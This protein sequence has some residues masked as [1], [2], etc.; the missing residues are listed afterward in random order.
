MAGSNELCGL[1]VITEICK[2]EHI[3]GNAEILKQLLAEFCEAPVTNLIENADVVSL[4]GGEFQIDII[5]DP[6]DGYIAITEDLT[7]Y[8]FDGTAWTLKFAGLG[9]FIASASDNGDD[10]Y[11]F[12]SFDGNT[13][14]TIAIPRVAGNLVDNADPDNPNISISTDDSL[15]FEAS[16]R[17]MRSNIG[18][19]TQT[20]TWNGG[21]QE[22]TLVDVPA[23]IIYIAVNGQLL[24]DMVNQWSIDVP[25]KKVTILDQLDPGDKVTVNYKFTITS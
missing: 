15:F 19:S 14:F 22:F 23:Q 21:A 17:E 7:F 16:T 1:D 5:E 2:K 24:V 4:G 12:T 11:T 20:F 8:E 3:R 9:G 18:Q 6:R 10:T 25:N 13:S